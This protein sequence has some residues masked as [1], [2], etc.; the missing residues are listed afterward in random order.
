MSESISVQILDQEIVQASF[1][2]ILLSLVQDFYLIEDL[3]KTDNSCYKYLQPNQVEAAWRLAYEISGNRAIFYGAPYSGT[4]LEKRRSNFRNLNSQDQ[5]LFLRLLASLAQAGFLVASAELLPMTGQEFDPKIVAEVEQLT[6]EKQ[7]FLTTFVVGHS[8]AFLNH[9]FLDRLPINKGDQFEKQNFDYLSNFWSEL[10]PLFA[11]LKGENLPVQHAT[12]IESADSILKSGGFFPTDPLKDGFDGQGVYVGLC[13]AYEGWTGGPDTSTLLEFTVPADSGVFVGGYR[14][15]MNVLTHFLN[16]DT[17]NDQA[18]PEGVTE[19]F[20]GKQ[21]DQT[22]LGRPIVDVFEAII[23]RD[24]SIY[25]DPQF[26]GE[27]LLSAETADLSPV[28]WGSLCK[29]LGIRRFVPRHQLRSLD[30][31]FIRRSPIN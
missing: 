10:E 9:Y 23:K 6:G 19:W 8:I 13:Y 28:V 2:S 17:T 27:Y 15:R 22:F 20:R 12:T 31:P 3:K 26:P 29:I 7:L 14:P 11:R 21:T 16:L 25:E 18:N 1:E 30:K 5:H 4:D 24:V